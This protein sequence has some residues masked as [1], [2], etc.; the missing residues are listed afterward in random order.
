MT[1]DLQPVSFMRRAVGLIPFALA[2]SLVIATVEFTATYEGF[3]TDLDRIGQLRV[4]VHQWAHWALGSLAIGFSLVVLEHRAQGSVASAV[5]YVVATLAGASAG[6]L[7]QTLE[8]TLRDFRWI[9][10]T[11]GSHIEWQDIFLYTLWTLLFWGALGAAWH[12]STM[13]LQHST[14]AFRRGELARL[15]SERRLVEARLEAVRAQIE[16]E[17]LL[18]SL[19]AVERLYAKDRGAADR[20]LDALIA[21][22]RRAMPAMR[23]KA[24]TVGNECRLAQS[25]VRAVWASTGIWQ[26][27]I[28]DISVEVDSVPMLSGTL[29]PVVQHFLSVAPAAAS[30]EA[31]VITAFRAGT[32]LRIDITSPVE[33]GRADASWQAEV[34]KF[35]QRF[36]QS[37]TGA[38]FELGWREPGL[39]VASA[40]LPL[41]ELERSAAPPFGHRLAG[42][43][44]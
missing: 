18:S 1:D 33:R 13:R 34:K 11:V 26:D 9:A 35:E 24:S 42:I 38:R 7:L 4:F 44:S 27:T 40:T 16:P 22:L 29:L 5:A 43:G 20:V 12:A 10:V 2:G 6:A 31:F 28:A 41:T 30:G 15:G 39:A 36:A 37:G 17:F 23:Q 32:D 19:S 14:E 21:F 25:Y 3:S 8:S